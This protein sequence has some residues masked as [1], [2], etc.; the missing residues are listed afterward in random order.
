MSFLIIKKPVKWLV[1][2]L[3]LAFMVLAMSVPFAIFKSEQPLVKGRY[4]DRILLKNARLLDPYS[5]QL[6]NG[7]F[8]VLEKGYIKQITTIEPDENTDQLVVDVEGQVVMPGLTDMHVHI[9]DRSDL[10]LNLAHGVT[11]VR[12]MHGSELQLNLREEVKSGQSIGP[13]M[14]V[15]SP[16]INQPSQYAHSNFHWFVENE[17]EAKQ[18]VQY[19]HKQKY[20]LIKVYDGLRPDIFGAIVEQGRKSGLPIAGHPSFFVDAEEFLS[21]NPQTLEHVEMLYQA[22]LDYSKDSEKLKTLIASLKSHQVAVTSTLVVF[23]NLVQIATRKHQYLDELPLDYMHPMIYDLF[24]PDMHSIMHIDNVE[25][26]AAKSDYLGEIASVINQ[27]NVPW[28]LGSDAGAGFTLNG[29]ATIDEMRLLAKHGISV[30]DILRS[31]TYLPAEVLNQSANSGR[32]VV[33][34]KANLVILAHDPRTELNTFYQVEGVIKD[35]I[36]Y[37]Q[38]GIAEMKQVAK[39]HMSNYE[40]IGWFLLDQWQRLIW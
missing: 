22:Y 20:D 25:Q 32:F 34:H 24:A 4:S 15:S 16:I 8:V 38:E 27:Y 18:L 26:W 31:A 14:I 21:T 29:M 19:F 11:Q 37:D 33:G 35:Q 23:D 7:Y 1:C 5:D 9:Y 13:D 28:I 36:Y 3:I 2:L 40:L 30:S 10:L 12:N 39:Q 17:D 6:L